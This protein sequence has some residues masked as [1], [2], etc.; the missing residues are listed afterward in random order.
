MSDKFLI[1][2]VVIV[3]NFIFK[4]ARSIRDNRFGNVS[5]WSLNF[6]LD[7]LVNLLSTIADHNHNKNVSIKNTRRYLSNFITD[8]FM[9]SFSF[10]YI[11]LSWFLLISLLF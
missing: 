11:L 4:N 6:G 9:E 8:Y 10:F 5:D 1:S 7:L 3:D 2:K